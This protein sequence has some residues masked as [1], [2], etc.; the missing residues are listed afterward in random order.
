M[1]RLKIEKSVLFEKWRMD[2]AL[3]G[4]QFGLRVWEQ[5]NPKTEVI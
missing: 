2:K 1:S 3:K 5:N 4:N